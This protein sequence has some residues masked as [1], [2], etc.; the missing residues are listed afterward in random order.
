[1]SGSAPATFA[2]SMHT[3]LDYTLF[4]IGAYTFTV[5]TMVGLFLVWLFTTLLLRAIRRMINRGGGRLLDIADKGRRMSIY[6]IARYFIWTI[7]VAIMLEMVGIHVSVILAGSAALL[8]GLGLGMQEIFRDIVSG[9]FLLFEGSIEIGDVLEVDGKVGRVEQISL[10]TS[11]LLTREGHTMIV[12]NHKFITQNV[13]NWTHHE[14]QP[15]AFRIQVRVAHEADEKQMTD[16]LLQA[17]A[18][19]PDIIQQDPERRTQAGL[20]DFLE[21]STLYEVKFWTLKKFEAEQIQSELRMAIQ[22]QLRAQGVP[23]PKD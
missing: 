22:G 17:A 18:A 2:R 5:A 16:I 12:P 23:F 1:M 19:H 4:S 9:I 7:A 11:K 14:A 10:R 15:S 8:V 21:K 6:L 13:L 3:F 20:A